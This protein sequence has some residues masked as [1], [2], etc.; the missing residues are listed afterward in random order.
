MEALA[1]GE[2]TAFNM[3]NALCG[4]L[5]LSGRIDKA[6]A[7]NKQLIKDGTEVYKAYR[8]HNHTSYPVWPCGRLNL[9]DK[10]HSALGFLSADGKKMTLAVWKFEDSAKVIKID[11]SKYF[12]G[13]AAN[14]KYVYPTA[15]DTKFTYFANT[16][17]LAIEMPKDYTARY[18]EITL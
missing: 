10:T 17:I 6:D 8:S 14:V 12:G 13:K 16:S 1:D 11:L 3:I 9:C 2:Q 18:F 5:Y 4:V 7:F 15:I